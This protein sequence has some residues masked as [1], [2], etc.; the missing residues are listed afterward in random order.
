MIFYNLICCRNVDVVDSNHHTN[1][2]LV[3]SAPPTLRP[4]SINQIWFGGSFL[5]H[6]KVLSVVPETRKWRILVVDDSSVCRKATARVLKLDGHYVDECDNGSECLF[7]VQ[8]AKEYLHEPYDACTLDDDMPLMTGHEAVKL[9]RAKG[10]YDKL[11]VIG[12]TGSRNDDHLQTFRD[13]GADIVIRKPMTEA[14]WKR[15][16]NSLKNADELVHHSDDDGEEKMTR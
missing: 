12:L 1:V 5:N 7:M 9:L 15:I 10:G 4:S 6:R 8:L 13:N 2:V 11:V 16:Y 3:P 14:L